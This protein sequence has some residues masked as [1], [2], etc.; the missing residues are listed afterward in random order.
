MNWLLPILKTLLIVSLKNIL[1]NLPLVVE[2]SQAWRPSADRTST[3]PA[4]SKLFVNL[5]RVR[6][7]PKRGRNLALGLGGPFKFSRLWTLSPLWEV[8]LCV[9]AR[10]TT[11][12]G[13][14]GGDREWW[15][16]AGDREWWDFEGDR[17]WWDFAGGYRWDFA[18]GEGVLLGCLAQSKSW[19]NWNIAK[20]FSVTRKPS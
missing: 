2:T 9:R 10:G 8:Q 5:H 3:S 12:E 19:K 1:R 7:V 17:E 13:K 15:D 6:G 18:A 20:L 16:F 11:L 14:G 4:L